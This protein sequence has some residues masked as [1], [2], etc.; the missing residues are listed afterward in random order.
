[1]MQRCAAA[2]PAGKCLCLE[3]CQRTLQAAASAKVE[4]M[5]QCCVG[6]HALHIVVMHACMQRPTHHHLVHMRAGVTHQP[7]IVT[8]QP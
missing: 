7:T 8:C 2:T 3:V 6:V 4:G 5:Y 1:M